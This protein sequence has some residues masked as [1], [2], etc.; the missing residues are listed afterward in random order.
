MSPFQY[1]ASIAIVSICGCG[2][3]KDGAEAA[4]ISAAAPAS[5]VVQRPAP[6][7]VPPAA[8][9]ATAIK[10]T[11]LSLPAVTPTA[12]GTLTPMAAQVTEASGAAVPATALTWESSDPSLATVDEA[13]VVKPLRTGFTTIKVSANGISASGTLSVRGTA[14]IPARSRY[15]GM[16]LTGIAYYSSEFPF[17]DIAKSGMGW[18]S[19][20]DNGTWGKAFPSLTADGYPAT[21]APGQHALNAVAWAGS[22]Y[23]P[24]RYVVLW[25]GDGSISFPL[26]NVTV[27]ESAP[28]RI[29][30]DAVDTSGNLWVAIDRTSAS[31][32]VRN[33]RFLW[34]G[35]EAT[36]ANQPFNPA[37]LAKI[38]PF[39][40]LRFIDWGA[41]NGS[42]IVEWAD[43]SHVGDVTY[44]SAAG[45][46]I[47]VMIDLA[48]TLHVDPWFCIPH[49]ASDD[50][51]RRFATLLYQRL[52]PALHP[53]I[54][55]S[56]E[57]WNTAFAQTTWANARSQALGLESPFGQPALFYA[58]RA[59]QL[60]KI[61]QDVWGADRGR[62]VRVLAGQAV[63]DNF[64]SHAL[65]YQ[66]TAANADVMAVAPYFNAVAA[67][68]PAQVATTLTLSSDQIVDQMLANI[69][70]A[71][72]SSMTSNA[73]LAA[74]YKLKFKAYE[75]GAGDSSSSFPADKIDAM[76]ALFASAHNNP[77]MRD[78]Y[79]EYYRQWIAAG[80]DTMNQYSDIGNW[81]K[82]GLWGSLQ[83]VTQDPAASP[84]YQG[85]LDAI[86]AHP[87]P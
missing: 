65:A 43:R 83:Y 21:L 85:L 41:T 74:K 37:F 46:P 56:N 47:E 69:R 39:S 26:S 23:A 75:S 42:P 53:H 49:Q 48:N 66:D 84:K 80:G 5:A 1:L 44:A 57:V 27:A 82:W 19:R 67:G 30:I 3:G 20:E 10:V 6:T 4:V 51:V 58:V 72:K 15:V 52:D 17:A 32:P 55:Y 60:F 76:T 63:W 9:P 25:D 59:V 78:V 79:A 33:L 29:A 50:Y 64:L 31:N 87:T 62:I 13:G 35:T 24:G 18:V 11:A 38:A 8:P 77:R 14:P 40:L 61:V 2:G 73:A 16:N 36:Y 71:I 7:P 81:S 86:A 12:V 28:N 68:D 45:V 34:P 22:H 70:G 54:E